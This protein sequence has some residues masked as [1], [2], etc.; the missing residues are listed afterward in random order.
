MSFKDLP[1]DFKCPECGARKEEFKKEELTS[2][3][4]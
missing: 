4:K 1:E 2:E 3:I